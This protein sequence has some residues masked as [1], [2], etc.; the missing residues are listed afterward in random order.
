MLSDA[1]P[2]LKSN[3][4]RNRRMSQKSKYD[5]NFTAGGLLFNEYK[6]LEKLL[7]SDNF[8]ELI[9]IEEEQ[10][11]VIGIATNSSRK[12]IIS[13]IKR[14]YYMAPTG[15]WNIYFHWSEDEQKLALLYL[16]LKTYPLILDI[17]LE[18][19]LKKFRIGANLV[20]YDVQMRLE[21]IM[22]YDEEVGN[23]SMLTLQKINEQY[24][25]ALKDAG[26]YHADNTLHRPMKA[27]NAFWEYFKGINEQWFIEACFKNIN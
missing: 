9:K 5:A 26:L 27:S 4:K 10:N 7:L 15:F 1:K 11:N 21:E 20:A 13:E 3:N 18:V 16:C 2:I 23:W 22:S 14:R 12:R 6:A 24:R 19:T 25:K 17:H 8:E